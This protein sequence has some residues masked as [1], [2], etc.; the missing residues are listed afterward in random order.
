MKIGIYAP[1]Y[2]RAAIAFTHKY[3]PEVQYVVGKSEAK[4]YRKVHDRIVV[5]PDRVQGNLCRV[6]NWILD[7]REQNLLLI[8][9]DLRRVGRWEQTKKKILTT[10]DCMEFIEHGFCLA[11]EAG[12][13]FWGLNLLPDKAAYREYTPF[14][15][16]QTIGG[17]WQAFLSMDLRYD[18][19]LSLKEDYDMSLQVLN[20][21]RRTL[22]FN[23]YFYECDQHGTPG[24]CASYRT[25]QRERQQFELLQ[26]KWGSEIVT[27]DHQGGQVN[28]KAKTNW[29]INPVVRCP[30]PGV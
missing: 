28:Q 26:K 18:E 16:K 5:V 20:K 17:P 21:Y 10:E 23:A 13:K 27:T 14:G 19:S 2:R 9:D 7:N 30:I 22:R 25:M 8:D 6:R 4:D 1:S 12:V 24:G 11:E 3:L 29:D 15:F